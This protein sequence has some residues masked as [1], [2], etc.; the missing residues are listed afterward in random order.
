MDSSEA[1][2]SG[3]GATTLVGIF[4]TGRNGSTL[5]SRLLDGI[6]GAYMHPVEANFLSAINDMALLP[7]VRP[8][9]IQNA[10]RHRLRRLEAPVP[11]RRLLRFY[12]AH[13]REIEN[14]HLA[15]VEHGAIRPGPSPHDVLAQ[16]RAYR[17]AEFVPAFLAASAS[18]LDHGGARHLMFKSIE[19]PYIADYERLFPTMRFIH[20]VRDPVSTW[21]S[22]KR[23]FVSRKNLPMWHLGGDT[24]RVALEC[25]WMPHAE[26][27]LARRA[28]ARHFVIRYEDLVEDA[29]RRIAEIC[30]WLGVHPPAAPDTQT[31]LG[32][33]HPRKLRVSASQKGVE[34]PRHAT[35]DLDTRH[36][37]DAVV[38]PR[39][40]DFIRLRTAAVAPGLGYGDI[41]P[42]AASIRKAWLGLDEWDFKNVRGLKSRALSLRCLLGRRLYIWRHC[43]PIR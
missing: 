43:R 40:R 17:A 13:F 19:T 18:W 1:I 26:A 9:T 41:T 30:A 38:S 3:G 32:G 35:A 21:A 7:I 23:T 27:V 14:Q 39:E 33:H 20:I 8:R 6:P 42:D 25:R 22:Q 37:Y 29:A 34:T 16:Q 28:D 5:I 2:P 11:T 15:E 10:V 12:D 31:V 24:F 36:G 4:G